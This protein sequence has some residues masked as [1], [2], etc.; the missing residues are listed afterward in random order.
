MPLA[1]T[2]FER[3]ATNI[4]PPF[5]HSPLERVIKIVNTHFNQT[6][7]LTISVCSGTLK[8]M[9]LPGPRVPPFIGPA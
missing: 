6:L 5:R 8:M 1:I 2:G 7:A 3:Y 9:F 4:A